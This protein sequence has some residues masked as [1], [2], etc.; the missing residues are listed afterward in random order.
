LIKERKFGA[1][2][3]DAWERDTEQ[4]LARGQELLQPTVRTL[5]AQP[6]LFGAQPTLADAALHGLFAMLEAGDPGLLRRFDPQ[7]L[8]W[9]RRV[10]ELA[11]ARRRA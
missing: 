3:V 7:L 5:S 2:C 11:A 4:L 8:A 9:I 6:F 1:G 10:D